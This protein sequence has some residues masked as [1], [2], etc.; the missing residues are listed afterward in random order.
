MSGRFWI[1]GTLGLLGLAWGGCVALV[2]LDGDVEAV[3]VAIGS[4]GPSAHAGAVAMAAMAGDVTR[5]A[6]VIEHCDGHYPCHGAVEVELGPECPLPLGEG[7]TGIIS[8]EGTW[9]S[10]HEA[11]LAASFTDV[12]IFGRALVVV[13]ASD[14][15]VHWSPEHDD[16]WVSFSDAIVEVGCWRGVSISSSD[17]EV[18]IDH[19]GSPEDPSDDVYVID[20]NSAVV[21]TTSVRDLSLDR[22]V[23]DPSCRLNPIAGTGQLVDVGILSVSVVDIAFH[24]TCDGEVE[25]GSS[26]SRESLPLDVLD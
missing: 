12:E 20:G 26:H 10:A 16:T 25:I 2:S 22:V 14:V 23:L 24:D 6:R 1:V 13:Q 7:G 21:R 8:V 17:W 4:V 3:E 19:M 15:V 9:H 5:C 11:T 18:L